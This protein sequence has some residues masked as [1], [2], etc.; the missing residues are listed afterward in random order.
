MI[1]QM[2]GVVFCMMLIF[3]GMVK[4]GGFGGDDR[5]TPGYWYAGD[6]PGLIDP[7][8]SPLVFVHGYNNSSAVWHEG[9]DMYEVALANGY[10]TAFID[11]HPDRDMW[12]NGAMLAEKL[13][14]MYHHFGGKKLVVVG[15]SKGGVDIQT[16][17]VHYGA[18]QYVSNVISLSS[19]HHGT[20]LADLA[21]SSAAWW[22][23]ALLGNNNEATESLQTGNMQYFRAITDTHENAA[24]NF[25]FT[26]G[27]TKWGSFG[28]ASYWGGLYLSQYG[29][30]DGVVTT[31]NSRLPGASIV[32]E[33]SWNHT[34]I[35][36]GSYTFQVFRPYTMVTQP[37]SVLASASKITPISQ[38]NVHS[39]V[40]GGK[41]V[42]A[43]N[44]HFAVEENVKSMTVSFL[45][46]KNLSS[47]TLT[48]PDGKEYKTKKV[49]KEGSEFFKGAWVHQF[50]MDAPEAGP[51]SL[52]GPR[53]ASY[54]YT[55][56]LDSP[57]N[58]TLQQTAGIMNKNKIY[59]TKWTHFGFDSTGKKL[60]E[61][62]KGEKSGLLADSEFKQEGVYNVTTEVRGVTSNGKPF[63]RTII[64]SFYVNK[65]GERQ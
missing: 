39:I 56:S 15:Y 65:D 64:E 17:L 14:D 29:K 51:W 41:A 10:E 57:L 13:E 36:E 34:T 27:G 12:A 6:T 42:N 24:K 28:S 1:K 37:A 38:P 63:E 2:A 4:A 11:L 16:A 60:Q 30:N 53:N 7:E 20:Q 31:V 47:L 54:L 59:K 48:G 45:S 58:D 5:G 18:H 8:K 26:L 50:E 21:H 33:G 62:T 44:D 22:L 43:L 23:A 9:N 61:K 3:P 49:Y 55:V 52:K 19:P 25:Y 40:K 46:E 32:Q 35:R